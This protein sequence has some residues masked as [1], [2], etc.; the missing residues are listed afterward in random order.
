M[1][2]ITNPFSSD[3]ICLVELFTHCLAYFCFFLC[4][5]EKIKNKQDL[6]LF[7]YSYPLILHTTVCHVLCLQV[8]L[9]P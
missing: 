1:A 7:L 8:C 5:C 4:W 3:F 6:D 9:S 2:M